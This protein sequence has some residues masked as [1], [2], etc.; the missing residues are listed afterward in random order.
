MR[1]GALGLACAAVAATL[2]L[3]RTGACATET[4]ERNPPAAKENSMEIA[5]KDATPLTKDRHAA[6]L[7]ALPLADRQD[8][9]DAERGFVGSLPDAA[10]TGA[11]GR[12]VWNLAPYDFLASDTPPPTVH[13]SLWRQAQLNMRHG[14]FQIAERIYQV[15]GLDLSNMDI[16]E[17]DTGLI[18]IDPLISAECA[19]AALELYFAHRPRKPVVA[20]LYTHSH[21]DHFG[22]VK[23]VISEEDAASGKV[24]VIAP[25]GFLE[26]AVSENVLAGNAMI[27]RATYMYGPLLQR[28]ARGQV[29]AGLGKNIS[30]GTVTLIPP[31][32]I[33]KE[34]GETRTIDGVKMEFQM[35]QGTEAP[36]EMII[37]FPQFRALCIAE[38]ATHTL[39]NLYTLRGAEVRSAQAWWKASTRRSTCSA[40]SRT[41]CLPSIIGPAGAATG[42]SIF[43]S[44]SATSTSSC[45]TRACGC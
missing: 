2:S 32:D 45:R 37:Y 14:L 10:I 38:V 30:T 33:V 8:F 43:S 24:K 18:V 26:H 16:I 36:A 22:G 6:A 19:K 42:S 1:L 40:T 11:D 3:G 12:S 7:K 39:H 44:T 21:V 28:G 31:N 25:E 13:P 17:G 4:D 20:V 23:G 29:D 5:P 35:A 9:A 41:S 34:T 15:R 27:R